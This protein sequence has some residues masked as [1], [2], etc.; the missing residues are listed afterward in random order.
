[1]VLMFL[2][3]VHRGVVTSI[4]AVVIVQ[5]IM[6]HEIIKVIQSERKEKQLVLFRFIL[7]YFLIVTTFSL[8]VY[9]IRAQLEQSWP[10]YVAASLDF[11]P[12]VVFMLFVIGFMA[13]VLSLKAGLYRYQF[14]Q[15]SGTVV[16]LLFITVQGSLIIPNM[17]RGM[18]WFLLPTSCVIINDTFAY[19]CGKAFG[20]RSLLKLSPKKTVEGFIGSAI[21]TIFWAWWFSSFL[22]NF[23]GL[24]CPTYDFTSPA[25]CEPSAMYVRTKLKYP[26][27]IP[28]YLQG[29]LFHSSGVNSGFF[30]RPIQLHALVLATFASLV[31]PFGGFFASGFK[32]AFK[33]KDFGALIPGHGGM[34]DRMDCQFIMAVFTYLY[35]EY[36]VEY[37]RNYICGNLDMEKMLLCI[38]HLKKEDLVAMRY[39]I[40]GLLR[41]KVN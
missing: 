40:K 10:M 26:D 23:P 41:D 25:T 34:T 15:F 27:F 21:F 36:F 39:Y 22:C 12:L 28:K 24:V 2:I 35:Y 29:F 20:H 8:T 31:A 17:L 11:Y 7:Y 37:D 1:M 19:L 30:Y 5:A 6:F 33:L 13:F 38:S 16:T 32:R 14:I 18:I 3:I 4:G 9:H